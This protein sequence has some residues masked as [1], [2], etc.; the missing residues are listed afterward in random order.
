[1]HV[2]AHVDTSSA[3]GRSPLGETLLPV[4]SLSLEHQYECMLCAQ[5]AG[6]GIHMTQP[7]VTGMA[8]AVHARSKVHDL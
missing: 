5:V 4:S 8:W 6:Q 2:N 7:P 1:M 3:A